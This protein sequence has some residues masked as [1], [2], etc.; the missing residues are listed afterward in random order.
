MDNTI[1]INKWLRWS[2]ALFLGVGFN[3][4]LD[5]IFSLVYT[6]YN[7][8]Q[9][10]ISYIASILLTYIVFECLFFVNRR[11]SSKYRWDKN[12]LLRFFFQ[13]VSNSA[14]AISIVV[15]SRW[16]FKLLFGSVYYISLL[17][18][19]III[20][21]VL[22]IVLV[23][24]I[25]DL[26]I[27]L[28]NSWRFSLAELE[29]FKKENAE[30]R[31]ESLRSQLNP[32]FLFNS[33][34]SLSALVYEDTE[35]AGLFIRELSDVYRYILENRDKELVQ[36]GEELNFAQSYINLIQLR[37][38]KNIVVV[39]NVRDTNYKFS[40]APLTIQLLIENAVKHNVIS[41]KYPLRIDIEIDKDILVVRNNLQLKRTKEYSN[42][43]GLNNIKSRYDF[44][45]NRMVEVVENSEEFIVKIPLI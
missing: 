34:N 7:L 19:L 39:T 29:R 30:F 14:I 12:T 9:P 45:T 20:S 22:F 32:H 36:L 16:G 43:M 27:Y 13:F 25:T 28:L 26:S 4:V 44:L 15:V 8:F 31:F 37:F 1:T 33:L 40:I 38:D 21:F 2:Y 24:T 17:D 3:F 10:L 6:N 35:K 5:V 11:L 41:K 42:K 23:F 18:E